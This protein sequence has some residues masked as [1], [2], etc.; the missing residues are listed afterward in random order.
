[1]TKK[2]AT[3][4]AS[5]P[6]HILA[7]MKPADARRPRYIVGNYRHDNRGGLTTAETFAVER[8]SLTFETTTGGVESFPVGRDGLAREDVPPG[9]GL[10]RLC[11]V[12]E[13]EN[14]ITAI[15]DWD[16]QLVKAEAAVLEARR[17][18]QSLL[19]HC[20]VRC[21]VVAAPK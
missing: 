20:A 13:D 5:E 18:R 9:W 15:A 3:R 10:E 8:D 1:M 14:L 4:P 17:K 12:V 16:D 2:K 19:H 21:K 7:S 6:H 11:R